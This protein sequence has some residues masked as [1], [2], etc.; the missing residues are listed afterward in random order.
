[1]R[2]LLYI[3]FVMRHGVQSNHEILTYEVINLH[4]ARRRNVESPVQLIHV[5]KGTVIVE[6]SDLEINS[7]KH[8]LCM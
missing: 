6:I 7:R 8:Y 4:R 2:F 5:L 3:F 1:M